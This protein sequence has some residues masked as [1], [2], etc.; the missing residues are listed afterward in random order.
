[1]HQRHAVSSK[2]PWKGCLGQ[3]PPLDLGSQKANQHTQAPGFAFPTQ[4]LSA[5]PRLVISFVFRAARP[6]I[7]PSARRYSCM[8]LA[9]YET[10]HCHH[11][12][13]LHCT[14]SMP[15]IHDQPSPVPRRGEILAG[16]AAGPNVALLSYSII[17][18]SRRRMLHPLLT[19]ADL[20]NPTTTSH[21]H[22][23]TSWCALQPALRYCDTARHV[24]P[25]E[26]G[27]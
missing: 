1:M 20:P 12:T 24:C 17:E 16:G 9:P 25:E 21:S 13:A 27:T 15:C 14:R 23:P 11:C 2:Q 8:T 26:N 19:W 6:A 7:D 18:L 4:S 5:S 10:R 3:P 22:F